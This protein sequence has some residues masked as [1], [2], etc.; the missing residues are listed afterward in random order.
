MTGADRTGRKKQKT[1]WKGLYAV[2]FPDHAVLASQSLL[3]GFAGSKNFGSV[4]L[5]PEAQLAFPVP[6]C[7]LSLADAQRSHLPPSASA[8]QGP[9]RRRRGGCILPSSSHLSICEELQLVCYWEQAK[10]VHALCKGSPALAA[11]APEYFPCSSALCTC[12]PFPKV[13]DSAPGLTSF[14]KEVWSVG[15]LVGWLVFCLFFCFVFKFLHAVISI[16]IEH[17]HVL[18]DL[19]LI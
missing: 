8:P 6:W 4:F 7:S 3:S 17:K 10:Q 5:S 16:A 14:S 11:T 9:G 15:C 2:P 13:Q 12:S 19:Q 1:K 18:A